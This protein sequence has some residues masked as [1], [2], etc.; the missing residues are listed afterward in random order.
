[1]IRSLAALRVAGHPR[2]HSADRGWG[3]R[4]TRAAFVTGS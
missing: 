2:E 3:S 1:V 4:R